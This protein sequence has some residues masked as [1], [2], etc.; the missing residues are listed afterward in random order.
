MTPSISQERFQVS[1]LLVVVDSVVQVTDI[2]RRWKFIGQSPK[3]SLE[4][5]NACV[6]VIRPDME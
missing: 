6:R 3:D 2:S 4:L 5:T 1:G